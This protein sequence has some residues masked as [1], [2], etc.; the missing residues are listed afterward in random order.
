MKNFFKLAAI[1]LGLLVL[2]L[3]Y[4]LLWA[5]F[6]LPKDEELINSI[7][8]ILSQHGMWIIFISALIEGVLIAGNYFPGGL[9]VFLG[10]LA[11]RNNLSRVAFVILQVTLAFLSAYSINYCLGKFGWY[12]LLIK[13]GYQAQLESAKQKLEKYS[14]KAI[15]LS[16]FHPNLGALISTSAGI[17]KMDFKKFILESLIIAAFWN[18][19]WGTVVYFF[20]KKALNLALN[21]KYL[22]PIAVLWILGI[23]IK[24]KYFTKLKQ[25]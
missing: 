16:Y 24:E 20:G 5:V 8:K 14:F 25:T 7:S 2:S 23:W 6:K 15:I 13:F 9:V 4:N 21:L 19:V 1:P 10:V 22:I 11:V 18:I 17:L 12:K 3:T